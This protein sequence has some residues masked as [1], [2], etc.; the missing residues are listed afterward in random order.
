MIIRPVEPD[1]AIQISKISADRSVKKTMNLSQAGFSEAEKL[2]KELTDLDHLL[3]L[4]TEMP[5]SEICGVVLLKIDPQI[6]L[7]R[8]AT[9]EI[10]LETK[11]QGQGLGKALL[12][13]ALE[14]A[15]KELMLER[16]EVEI[17]LDN[18]NALKLFKSMGFKVEGT[19]KD[20]AVTED[21]EYI[22]AYLLARCRP[23]IK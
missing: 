22:D 13:A 3:V 16:V 17:A 20:W 8:Q 14:L 15:D 18:L 23:H 6:Y 2:I 19:A 12:I 9:L 7:R 21:G 1:D 5:P 11:W 10:M 4:E